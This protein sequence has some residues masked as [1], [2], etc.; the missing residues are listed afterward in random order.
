VMVLLQGAL[1]P[2]EPEAC[3]AAT[4]PSSLPSTHSSPGMLGSRHAAGPHAR[5]E[6]AAAARRRCCARWASR[7]AWRWQ[8]R[9]PRR[10][11]CLARGRRSLCT[12]ALRAAAVS[13][14]TP[15]PPCDRLN[16][17]PTSAAAAVL[18]AGARGRLTWC[19]RSGAST[20]CAPQQ[21]CGAHPTHSALVWRRGASQAALPACLHQG[22]SGE[23]NTP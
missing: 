19:G 3:H 20:W 15:C 1:T 18:R 23:C 13:L 7:R 5:P 10:R 11:P 22:A 12:G 8:T 16:G 6:R 14:C 21:Q 17:A 9:W 2:G 4:S